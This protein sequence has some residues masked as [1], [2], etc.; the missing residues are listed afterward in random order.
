MNFLLTE[1]LTFL[2]RRNWIFFWIDYVT[3]SRN[4]LS[5]ICFKTL[6]GGW[7]ERG[8]VLFDEQALLTDLNTLSCSQSGQGCFVSVPFVS[9]MSDM[10]SLLDIERTGIIS[11]RVLWGEAKLT[12]ARGASH[13]RFQGARPDH[14]QVES[15]SC[16]FPR[17]LLS[18]D[19][20]HVTR[21]PPIG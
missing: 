1:F 21:S 20:W 3:K 10:P 12:V 13:S 2:F 8:F 19:P 7:E 14:V 11:T 5:W 6:T 4:L 16:Y 18:F 9:T 17:E 15:S